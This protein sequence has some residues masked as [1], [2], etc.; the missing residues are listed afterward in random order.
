MGATKRLFN[1]IQGRNAARIHRREQR[2]K[3]DRLCEISEQKRG[4]W[5]GFPKATGPKPEGGPF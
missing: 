4:G 2:E 5:E 3:I 1:D